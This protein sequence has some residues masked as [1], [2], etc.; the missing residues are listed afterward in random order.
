[1]RLFMCLFILISYSALGQRKDSVLYCRYPSAA[2][3]AGIQGSVEI[4]LILKSNCSVMSYR[5]TQRLGYGCDEAAVECLL[6][7][8]K[9]VK[10][11]TCVTGKEIVRYVKFSLAE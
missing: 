7:R 10:G 8:L 5:V 2:R 4:K 3:K 11:D 6:L 9:K 1:M